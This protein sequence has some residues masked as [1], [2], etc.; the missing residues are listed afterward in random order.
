MRRCLF[1][2]LVVCFWG[3]STAFAADLVVYSGA[4]LMKPMEELRTNFETEHGVEVDIHYGSSG[5]LFGMLKMGQECD[6]LVPGSERYTYDALRNGWIQEDSIKKMVKHVPVIAVPKGN[7]GQIEGL[8]DFTRNGLKLAMGD[9]NSP[10][11]GRV[12]RKIFKKQGLWEAVKPNI[13]V[14]APTVNQLLVYVAMEQV[15][16]ALI[17]GDLVTWAEAKGKVEVVSIAKEANIIKTIPT[18][19]TTFAE[20]NSWAEK[21]SAYISSEAGL[22][23]WTQWG[24]EPCSGR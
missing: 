22:A 13:D 6:V 20:G 2:V 9:P 3:L 4:G 19:L 17:W 14:Y 23:I 1:V 11:I 15:D 18:G 16:G 21:F 7:P 10:A 12:G 5:E 8:Q 24:F